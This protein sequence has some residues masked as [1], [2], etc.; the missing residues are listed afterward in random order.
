MI[1]ESSKLRCISAY[2]TDYLEDNG[3]LREYGIVRMEYY[4][5]QG[6]DQWRMWYY[7]EHLSQQE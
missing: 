1:Q 3:I 5:G 6:S 2:E 7:E 4:L